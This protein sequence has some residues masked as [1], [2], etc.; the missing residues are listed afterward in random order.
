M[1]SIEFIE[2][3]LFAMKEMEIDISSIDINHDYRN[4]HGVISKV[5]N[6]N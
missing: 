5:N 2:G 3:Y 6:N 4:S 1:E